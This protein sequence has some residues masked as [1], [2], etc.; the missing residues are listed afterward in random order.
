MF[1]D[2]LLK[3]HLSNQ[4]FKRRDNTTSSGN[5]YNPKKVIIDE[6]MKLLRP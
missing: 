2:N 3:L 6:G 1:S 5:N 4:V